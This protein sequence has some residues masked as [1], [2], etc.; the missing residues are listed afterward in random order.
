MATDP[1]RFRNSSNRRPPETSAPPPRAS[2]NKNLLLAAL[3]T[4][5][6]SRLAPTLE[7]V[8]APVKQFLQ[9]PGERLR[10]RAFPGD[11]S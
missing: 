3:P 9:R 7:C 10:H 4:L 5:E 11:G 8:S 1:V 2:R 6:Y